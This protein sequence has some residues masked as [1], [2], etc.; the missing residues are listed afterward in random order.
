MPRASLR[1][2]YDTP[3][4]IQITFHRPL[5]RNAYK[6]ALV[7]RPPLRLPPEMS[8]D[9]TG[10]AGGANMSPKRMKG[11]DRVTIKIDKDLWKVITTKMKEH[12]E[13]GMRSVSDFIRRAIANELEE[14]RGVG[15]KK[16]IE[17][18]LSPRP[19][20]EGSRDKDP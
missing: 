19:S 6:S 2:V 20:R 10:L 15:D 18:R 5:A 8:Q 16:V 4:G 9:L 13:W 7:D 14:R 12:P 11:D 3:F 1:D 17:I